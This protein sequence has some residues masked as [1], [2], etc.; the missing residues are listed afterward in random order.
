MHPILIK[1]GPVSLYTYGLFVALGFMTALWIAR[2]EAKRVGVN[3]TNVMD[4]GFYLLI[5]AIV[6]SRLFFLVV[7]P[8]IISESI[9][10]IFQIWNGG[11]VFYGGFIFAL[12]TAIVYVRTI[13]V[14]FFKIADIF[15]PGLAAGHAVGRIG[16]F[17]AGCC[18]GKEC[19]LPWAV[20]F[21]NPLS[22]APIGVHLH[23]TQIYSVLGNLLVFCVLWFLRKRTKYTGQLFLLYV[24]FYGL[25]RSFIELF[26]GDPRGAF[27]DGLSVS[28]GIGLVLAAS[29][30]IVLFI[31]RKRRRDAA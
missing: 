27:F 15:A 10:G 3:P 23:P 17:F 29:A 1:I 5:A 22:L 4:L 6:G 20:V 2:L 7:N 24:M 12:I 21:D 28:Q 16:C 13:K 18:Y 11:L 8:D 14:S 25:V 26:R 30:A 9:W 19:N 31:M